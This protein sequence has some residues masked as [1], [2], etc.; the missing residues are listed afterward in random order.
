VLP[1][2]IGLW[3]CLQWRRGWALTLLCVLCLDLGYATWINPMGIA[4]RQVGHA[5]GALL[6]LL[7]GVGTTWLHARARLR[8]RWLSGVAG[9]VGLGLC[10][11]LLASAAW[12]S[13]SDGYVI[14]ERYGALSPWLDLPPR[15]VY[16]CSSDTACAS[17]LF[18]AYAEGTRPDLAVAPAQHLWDYGVTRRLRELLPVNAVVRGQVLP[19]AARRQFAELVFAV[20]VSSPQPRPIYLESAAQVDLERARLGFGLAHPP[21]FA[22]DGGSLDD[23]AVLAR[24]SALEQARFG[25]TGPRSK[26]ARE[27]WASAYSEI[28]RAWLRSGVSASA[29]LA[30]QWAVAL[31]PE[32]ASAHI[33]LGVA[34]EQHGDLASALRETRRALELE[35]DRPTPWLNLARLMLRSSGPDAALR[36]LD[37]AARRGVQDARL[38]QLQRQLAVAQGTTGK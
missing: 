16:L 27:S 35:I 14:A 26:L 28:G 7:A 20:L 25:R 18:A 31:T 11:Q 19:P 13:E 33:N 34:F 12:P 21:L 5:S 15:A 6:A 36:V 32:R 37:E 10:L 9:L 30:L 4:E 2:A 8:A 1:A 23:D 22:A 3:L 17:A 24:L 29:W 38:H